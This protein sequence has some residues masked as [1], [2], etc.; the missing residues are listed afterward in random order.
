MCYIYIV[1]FCGA[2]SAASLL[3]GGEYDRE[4]EALLG[5]VR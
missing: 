4:G 2:A 1:N 3:F 5:V